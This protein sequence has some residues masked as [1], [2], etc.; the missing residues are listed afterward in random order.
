VIQIGLL[1]IPDACDIIC[2]AAA[3]LA[4]QTRDA[5]LRKIEDLSVASHVRADLQARNPVEVI[6]EDGNVCIVL[7]PQKIKKSDFSTPQVVS[8]LRERVHDHLVQKVVGL[9][10]NVPGV[11]QV[12]YDIDMP[13][14]S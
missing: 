4:Y 7:P 14:Y 8:H 1:S 12:V 9:A 13:K 5:D 2:N 6:S 10:R 11:R 3:S